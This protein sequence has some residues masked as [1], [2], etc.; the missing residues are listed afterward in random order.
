MVQDAIAALE[1]KKKLRAAGRAR[2][3]GSAEGGTV[4]VRMHTA[5]TT[6]DQKKKKSL[7]CQ[8][9]LFVGAGGLRV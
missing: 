2:T 1:G 7:L 4:P 9:R 3:N 6:E 8:K 5:Q